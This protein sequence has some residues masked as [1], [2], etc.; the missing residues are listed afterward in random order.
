MESGQNDS[1]LHWIEK[2]V[3]LVIIVFN[4]S[5]FVVLTKTCARDYVTCYV[6]RMVGLSYG[7]R[8]LFQHFCVNAPAQMLG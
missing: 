6:R 5:A 4:S 2:R 1:F 3:S 7:Q 8:L